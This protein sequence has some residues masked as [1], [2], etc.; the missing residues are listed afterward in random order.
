M[1][2]V[3]KDILGLELGR[4]THFKYIDRDKYKRGRWC[5]NV[6]HKAS[7]TRLEQLEEMYR[8]VVRQNDACETEALHNSDQSSISIQGMWGSHVP[9]MK[10]QEKRIEVNEMRMLWWI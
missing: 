8:S 3:R 4:V 1:S 5:G 2:P 9:A 6:N 10:R 7:G